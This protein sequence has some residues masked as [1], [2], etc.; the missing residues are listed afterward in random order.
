[1]CVSEVSPRRFLDLSF[2]LLF[3]M[4]DIASTQTLLCRKVLSLVCVLFF[5]DIFALE[6]IRLGGLSPLPAL[7][8]NKSFDMGQTT[9][10]TDAQSEPEPF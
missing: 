1:M 10:V 3:K 8:E 2:T 7:V 4:I 9:G 5:I 6:N